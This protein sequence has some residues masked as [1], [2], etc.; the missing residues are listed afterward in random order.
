MSLHEIVAAGVTRLTQA[1]RDVPD[2]AG[3]CTTR[4]S[5]MTSPA[6]ETIL[7]T[8]KIDAHPH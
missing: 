4:C 5:R 6:C 1:D 8:Y 7:L 3:Y 2:H